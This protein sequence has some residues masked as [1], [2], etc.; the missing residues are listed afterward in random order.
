MTVFQTMQDRVT[1]QWVGDIALTGRLVHPA[2]H[3]QLE[4]S[5]ALVA[6]ELGPA[7]LR[8]GNWEA[9]LLG[10]E[11]VTQ[12]KKIA[13]HTDEAT[14]TKVRS[15]GLT[16]AILA[17]NHVLDCMASGMARTI[18]FLRSVGSAT[19]GAG[20]SIEE[21]TRPLVYE[22]HGVRFVVLAYVASETN[23][24]ASQETASLINYLE[25][26]RVIEEISSWAADG[27]VVLVHFH[28]GLD[29]LPLPSPDQRRLAHR[30]IDA[31]AAVVVGYHPHRL[32]G[33]ERRGDGWIFYS[34]GN[35]IAGDIYPWP[36]FTH[37]TTAVTCEFQDRR[38]VDVRLKYFIS[39]DGV[40]SADSRGRGARTHDSLN[41]LFRAP[42]HEYARQWAKALSYDLA[43][44]RP[45]HFF[46]R[47]RNPFRLLASLERRHL[48]EY[49]KVLRKLLGSDRAGRAAG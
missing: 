21:A 47:H 22:L 11:G 43:L 48:E 39:R 25:P 17:N 8:I 2:N 32:Q 16:T 38:I 46:R 29:F 7:D 18:A 33:F 13:L 5:A 12:G 35:L 34:L 19:V 1:I 10:N 30:V 41:P 9:P 14:A 45:L 42:D 36:R 26:D 20:L 28:W 40:V 15:L 37:P 31:G 44:T 3:H 49:G 27:A 4:A 24:R 23:P 6:Q